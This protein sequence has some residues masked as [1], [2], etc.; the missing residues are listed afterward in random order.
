MQIWWADQWLF[1][2]IKRQTCTWFPGGVCSGTPSCRMWWLEVCLRGGL[3]RWW[4]LRCRP[5]GTT[6]WFVWGLRPRCRQ[7]CSTVGSGWAET[8]LRGATSDL[9]NCWS[10]PFRLFHFRCVPKLQLP[11][12]HCLIEDTCLLFGRTAFL[13]DAFYCTLDDYLKDQC[14]YYCTLDFD[15]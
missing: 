2:P 8:C 7:D 12:L 14:V 1:L 3:R 4:V 9:R 5:P 11:T 6:S 10:R 13:L 15:Q